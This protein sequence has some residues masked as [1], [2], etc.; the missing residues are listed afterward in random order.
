MG[1]RETF[2]GGAHYHPTPNAEKLNTRN[3]RRWG[4][5]KGNKGPARVPLN[6]RILIAMPL[7]FA[8]KRAAGHRGTFRGR[9][10]L[11]PA[12]RCGNRNARPF[13]WRA[14]CCLVFLLFPG[15]VLFWNRCPAVTKNP[16]KCITIKNKLH[17]SKIPL[18]RDPLKLERT[19]AI[20][21]SRKRKSISIYG[22]NTLYRDSL[23]LHSGLSSP[24]LPRA[25]KR[26]AL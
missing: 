8:P 10:A 26:A 7:F 2:R 1:P 14:W 22:V 4:W 18:S 21:I 5:R 9:R 24:G 23:Y 16:H 3:A 6:F 15:W 19:K 11:P 25:D 12:A 20:R 17:I 13:N